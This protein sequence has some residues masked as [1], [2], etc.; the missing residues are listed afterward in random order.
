VTWQVYGLARGPH[1]Q[2]AEVTWSG[3]DERPGGLVKSNMEAA[4][5]EAFPKFFGC[6]PL[7]VEVHITEEV[8]EHATGVQ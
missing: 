4:L 8:S 6:D 1:G 3:L 5:Y 7:H 2:R